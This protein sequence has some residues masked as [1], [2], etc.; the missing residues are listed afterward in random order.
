MV[1]FV[2]FGVIF[3]KVNIQVSDKIVFFFVLFMIQLGGRHFGEGSRYPER[4]E[5]AVKINVEGK[6]LDVSV[7]TGQT[8]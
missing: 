3:L 6:W 2:F 8:R 1:G 5:E 4:M 7:I